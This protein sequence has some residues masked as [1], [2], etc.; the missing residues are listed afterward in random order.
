M[1]VDVRRR[2]RLKKEDILKGKEQREILYLEDYDAEVEIRP[3]SDGELTEIFALL[4]SVQLRE[5]G[6]PDTSAMDVTKNFQALRQAAALGLIE[7]QLT[8]DEV[9]EMKFGV[10][11][12]IGTKVLEISGVTS[13]EEAKKKG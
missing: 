10:P 5:D 2:K 3:L 9:A 12:L 7:P 6:A 8:A 1:E 11:E 4:G 13:S